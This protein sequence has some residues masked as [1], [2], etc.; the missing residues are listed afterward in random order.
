MLMRIWLCSCARDDDNAHMIMSCERAP[1]IMHTRNSCC[2]WH[3]KCTSKQTV[4]WSNLQQH[5]CTKMETRK[6]LACTI[7]VSRKHPTNLSVKSKVPNTVSSSLTFL[8]PRRCCDCFLNHIMFFSMYVNMCV[9]VYVCVS[10]F[11]PVR[12]KLAYRFCI[13]MCQRVFSE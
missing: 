2:W 1:I 4:E 3:G 10:T 6:R 11:M 7:L 9:C 12:M 13:F 8:W 5:Q